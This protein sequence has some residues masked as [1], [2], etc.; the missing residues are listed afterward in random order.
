MIA[1][2]HDGVMTGIPEGGMT[3]RPDNLNTWQFE[4]LNSESS[5]TG[6]S[7]NLGNWPF[8]DLDWPPEGYAG[9]FPTD[10]HRHA[11]ASYVVSTF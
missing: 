10:A 6:E 11:Y 9:W 1:C 7:E 2:T 8:E 5:W 3:R 4:D